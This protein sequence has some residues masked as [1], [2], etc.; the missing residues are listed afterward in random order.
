MDDSTAH[1]PEPEAMSREGKGTRGLTDVANNRPLPWSEAATRLSGGWFWLATVRPDGAP[2]VMPVMAA[3]AD[4]VL[5]VA[6]KDRARKSRNLAADARCVL[7]KD[8]GDLHVVIEGRARRVVDEA[9][10]LRAST[11]WNEIGWPTEPAG[12]V[13]DAEF[14]APTSGGPPYLVWEITPVTAFAFPTDGEWTTPTR[15]RFEP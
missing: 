10:L 13:L 5:Y 6:S 15:W 12:E 4:P 7:T 14:G 1:A 2:H 3:W 8:T 11:T 9:G